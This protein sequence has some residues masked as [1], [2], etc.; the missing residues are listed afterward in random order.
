M[1]IVYSYEDVKMSSF[2]AEAETIAQQSE[3]NDMLL[4]LLDMVISFWTLLVNVSKYKTKTL[5][6]LFNNLKYVLL[7]IP[8]SVPKSSFFNSKCN[9]K[10]NIYPTLFD[11]IFLPVH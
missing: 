1:W 11:S 8:R 3:M 6:F 10:L 5:G 7:K 2:L 4:V 9:T